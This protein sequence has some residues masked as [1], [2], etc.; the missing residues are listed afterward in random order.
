MGLNEA[1]K[2]A[3]LHKD[4]PCLVLAGP[5]SGK[6][7]TIVNRVKYLIE[8]NSGR[9]FYPFCSGGDEIPPLFTYGKRETSGDDR[10]ISWDLLWNPSM[11]LPDRTEES[12]LG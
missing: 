8:G 10:D 4:G 9:Y 6:T 2:D 7:L 11:D 1:Q 5:G 3:V 12:A